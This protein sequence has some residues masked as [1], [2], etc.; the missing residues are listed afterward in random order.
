MFQATWSQAEGKRAACWMSW[1]GAWLLLLVAC[2]GVLCGAE[3]TQLRCGKGWLEY[4]D[5]YPVLHLKGAPEEMGR[6]HGA[7]LKDHIRANLHNLLHVKGEEAA[8]E[9]GPLKLKPRQLVERIIALQSKYVPRRYF[10]ELDA[11]ADA[12]GVPRADARQIS[13]PPPR[14]PEAL[15][16][17][18]PFFAFDNGTGRGR[19]PPDEQARM[20][21]EL[22]YDGI[23]YTGT[24]GIPEMLAALDRHGLKM[25]SIYVG[26][27]VAEGAR[28]YDPALPEAIAQ[29]KGRKTA[30]WLFVRGGPPSSDQRD[31]RAVEILC[32]LADMAA[33]SDLPVVL[34]PHT[35]FY[36]ATTS[37]ALRLVEKANRPNL[38]VSFNL[39]HFLKA[40]DP[41]SLE[42]L[43]RKAM[44]HLLLA[45]INGA[46]DGPTHQMGWDR[47]IQPLD[48]GSYDV[49]GVLL[50][51]R[52][53]GYAGPIGLQC[54][55]IKGE[56]RDNLRRSMQ[57][58][59]KFKS[60]MKTISPARLGASSKAA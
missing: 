20:L 30:I 43:L 40:D 28:P 9:L 47:L 22:G 53:L 56:P 49:F 25:F 46:D 12:A 45:S 32:E 51:L 54:Y 58:W 39:C 2:G 31:D 26:A 24:A 57:A 34:Y 33:R 29:L 6:Q 50:A 21:K 55:A 17:N 18:N 1:L 15:E 7:L 42:A 8:V 5:G 27:N 23:G 4:I 10:R 16:L 3:A 14:Q 44:P 41:A 11:M 37:D 13:L 48:R 59:R 36:V 38:G 35:G 19:L 60:R 52:R